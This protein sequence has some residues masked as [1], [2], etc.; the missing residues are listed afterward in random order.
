MIIFKIEIVNQVKQINVFNFSNNTSYDNSS[1]TNFD[2]TKNFEIKTRNK[3]D[4]K[5]CM[6]VDFSSNIC[7]SI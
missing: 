5:G 6:L 2:C 3:L 4:L 1:D 7:I